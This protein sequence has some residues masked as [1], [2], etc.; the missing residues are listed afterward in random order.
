MTC[1]GKYGGDGE[2]CHGGRSEQRRSDVR[3]WAMLSDSE[4]GIQH[5]ISVFI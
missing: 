2:I 3:A 4:S 5:G 1:L